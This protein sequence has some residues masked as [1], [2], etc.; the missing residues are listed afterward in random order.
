MKFVSRIA[1]AF[2]N[3]LI[4]VGCQSAYDP[5]D[6]VAGQGAV[7]VSVNALGSTPCLTVIR[8]GRD[9]LFCDDDRSWTSAQSQ[10]RARGLE[11]VRIGD[12]AENA[13]VQ[14]RVPRDAC[15]SI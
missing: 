1:V 11:L 10:C 4:M 5:N 2:I 12:L 15:L 3:T 7:E 14:S 9:Y 8:D 13:F 6:G